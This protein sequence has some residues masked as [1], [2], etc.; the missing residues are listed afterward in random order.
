MA[1]ESMFELGIELRRKGELR[2]SIEVFSKILQD[3]ATDKRTYRIYTVLAGVYS[4]LGEHDKALSNFKMATELNPTS[5]LA[6]LG[7]YVTLAKLGRDEDAIHE[8][9]RYLKSYP[10]DLYKDTL[11]ELLEGLE[12]GYMS[13][14]EYDIRSFAKVNG[15]GL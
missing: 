1:M 6:S 3:F 8:L 15:V 13:N 12:S 10:A 14:F 4:D 7:L 9:I 11:E 2:E 5:E